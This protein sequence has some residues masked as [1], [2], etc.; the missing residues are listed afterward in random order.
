MKKVVVISFL[1]VFCFLGLI[2][3]SNPG[4]GQN[5]QAFRDERE[6]LISK[7]KWRLGPFSVQPSFLLDFRYDNNIYGKNK[8][9]NPISDYIATFSLPFSINLLLGNWLIFSLPDVPSY[10]YYFEHKQQRSFNNSYAPTLRILLF[11]RFPISGGYLYS[12]ARQ[13]WTTEMDRP[14]FLLTR[15]YNGSFFY[16][17]IRST[18]FGVA[19][20]MLEFNYEDITLPRANV[21]LAIALNRIEKNAR[22]EFY[23]KIFS[24][25]FFF[26]TF[27]YTENSFDDPQSRFR[28]S[29]SYQAYTGIRFP[30]IGRAE[31]TLSV[32]YKKLTPKDK[33][34]QGYS[35]PVGNTGLNLRFSRFG[36]RVQYIR[37]VPFSYE[38][39]N[40]FYI[41][42][43]LGAGIS[44]YLTQSIRLDYDFSHGTGSYP[45]P[46]QIILPD[47]SY[48]EIAR[49]DTYLI[50]SAGIV[51]RI[52]RNIGIGLR[53]NYWERESNDIQ[54]GM[55]RGLVGVYMT[56]DF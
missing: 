28:D 29:Y 22:L 36:F 27:G 33:S 49:Q 20:S 18:S 5:Y 39:N 55:S 34:L 23:R 16:D 31:G 26:A 13:Q 54:A 15:G 25:S 50:H 11:N 8:A 3:I 24:D 12:R 48:G 51:F 46:V 6:S 37:D 7:S 44:I 19:A 10:D 30:L 45:E 2:L 42:N 40:I 47:G 9:S 43:T 17:T 32:G 56:Y 41:S 14:V 1:A 35:G 38:K 21:P 53:A 52:I 4:C